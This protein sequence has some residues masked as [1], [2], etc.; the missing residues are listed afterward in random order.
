MDRTA[1]SADQAQE[2]LDW[3]RFMH[4]SL[5]SQGLDPREHGQ[6]NE[7][8]QLLVNAVTQQNPPAE[9]DFSKLV[10]Q[11][12][13]VDLVLTGEA[14]DYGE[15]IKGVENIVDRHLLQRE[16]LLVVNGKNA[17]IDSSRYDLL[18]IL[19]A[20]AFCTGR[21]RT[22]ANGLYSAVMSKRRSA[23]LASGSARSIDFL[24]F[25]PFFGSCPA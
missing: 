6:N 24:E 7:I 13:G 12:V 14:R 20:M 25:G 18:C 8:F 16:V 23:T 10:S 11:E 3:A 2:Q 5:A 1:G 15:F 4:E 9:F 22:A 19:A 21:A 17:P